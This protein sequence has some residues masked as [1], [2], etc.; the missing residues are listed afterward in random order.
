MYANV[1]LTSNWTWN[2]SHSHNDAKPWLFNTLCWYYMLTFSIGADF[3][4]TNNTICMCNYLNYPH[5]LSLIVFTKLVCIIYVINDIN[6]QS[7]FQT[8]THQLNDRVKCLS[9]FQ[10]ELQLLRMEVCVIFIYLLKG[11]LFWWVL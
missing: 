9:W 10:K 11:N 4:K 8:A 7:T 5:C 6:H 1:I 2:Q 3:E